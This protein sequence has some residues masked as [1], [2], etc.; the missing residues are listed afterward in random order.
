MTVTY[1]VQLCNFRASCNSQICRPQY[2]YFSQTK[3]NFFRADVKSKFFF[4]CIRNSNSLSHFL[5]Q[6]SFF[7]CKIRWL[8]TDQGCWADSKLAQ[9]LNEIPET[10]FRRNIRVYSPTRLVHASMLQF[11]LRSYSYNNYY[12]STSFSMG[13]TKCLFFFINT[14]SSS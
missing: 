3:F 10:P 6:N 8:T 11:Q 7:Q 1:H 4:Q 5:V 13:P 9:E 14:A 2:P 12:G